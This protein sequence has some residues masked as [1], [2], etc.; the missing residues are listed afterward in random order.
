MIALAKR[1]AAGGN[2][3][4]SVRA[5]YGVSVAELERLIAGYVRSGRHTGLTVEFEQKLVNAVTANSMTI[6]DAEAD[7]WLGDSAGAIGA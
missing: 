2:A 3:E 6:T 4:E 7:V 1:L 5:L